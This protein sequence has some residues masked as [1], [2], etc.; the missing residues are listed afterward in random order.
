[1]T[2][3]HEFGSSKESLKMFLKKIGIVKTKN[4]WETFISTCGKKID[5]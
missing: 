5:L 1:M 4:S 2:E 3:K